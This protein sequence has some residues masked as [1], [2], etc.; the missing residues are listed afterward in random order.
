MTMVQP[1][2]LLDVPPQYHGLV[3]AEP[4]EFRT[5]LIHGMAAEDWLAA[6]CQ[7]RGAVT[8]QNRPPQI[9]INADKAAGIRPIWWDVRAQ[10]LQPGAGEPLFIDVKS[11]MYWEPQLSWDISCHALHNA[12]RFQVY[13]AAREVWFGLVPFGRSIP[14]M[15]R[16]EDVAPFGTHAGSH[17]GDDCDSYWRIDAAETRLATLDIVLGPRLG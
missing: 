3:P 9:F 4:S 17:T 14:Y 16:R 15:I 2:L 10:L 11:R 8:V 1:R 6:E 5:R 7:A 12:W 13:S